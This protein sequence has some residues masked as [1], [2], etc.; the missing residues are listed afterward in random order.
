MRALSLSL[1]YF[2]FLL[3]SSR[4]AIPTEYRLIRIRRRYAP[5][6]NKECN[7]VPVL[8]CAPGKME[9]PGNWQQRNEDSTWY[10]AKS[11]EETHHSEH[12]SM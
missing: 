7:F 1:F 9:T 11:G 3:H 12:K 8:R 5:G 6:A 4:A 2:L 10:L